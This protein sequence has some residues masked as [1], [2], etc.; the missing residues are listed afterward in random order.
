V[1]L[2]LVVLTPLPNTTAPVGYAGADPDGEVDAPDQTMLFEPVY[3]V[4]VL[5][6]ASVAVSVIPVT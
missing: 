2:R 4:T 6:A 3:D 5:P 1:A